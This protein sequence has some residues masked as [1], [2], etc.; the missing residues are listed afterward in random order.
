MN[1]NERI[2]A[3][4]ASAPKTQSPPHGER[5]ES[6]VTLGHFNQNPSGI[7][8]FALLRED[9]E[10]HEKDFLSQGLWA[11]A[12]HRFGNWRMGIRPKLLRLPFTILYKALYKFVEWTC[13]ISLNYTVLVGRRVHIWHHGGMILGALSIGNGVHIRQ[14]TTFGVARRGDGRWMK[15]TI[16]DRVDIGAGAVIVGDITIGHD[17]GIGAN[18]V[19]TKDVPPNHIAVGVP[20]VLKKRGERREGRGVTKGDDTPAESVPSRS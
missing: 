13:G 3:A 14:N 6:D 15:P 16:G 18:A 11:I 7:G 10:T 5:P 17:S 20:A 12:V 1:D 19:V 8:F 2:A 9:W 4:L